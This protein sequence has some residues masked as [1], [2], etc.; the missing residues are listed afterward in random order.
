[1]HTFNASVSLCNYP[2]KPTS[3]E[4][5]EMIFIQ[6]ELN[7]LQLSELI[8]QGHSTCHLFNKK[9]FMCLNKTLKNFKEAYFIVLDFDHSNIPMEEIL[10]TIIIKPTIAFETFSNKEND[11]RFKMIYLLNKVVTD[12]NEYKRMTEM[13]FNIVFN[14]SDRI[15]LKNVL[16]PSSYTA[17]QMFHGTG[18][19]KRVEVFDTLISIDLI[20]QIFELEEKVFE[21]Y[22]EVYQF[23]GIEDS[24]KPTKKSKGK[25]KSKSLKKCPKNGNKRIKPYNIIDFSCFPENGTVKNDLF[26]MGINNEVYFIPSPYNNYQSIQISDQEYD[27]VYYWVGTQKIYAVNT[28]F[29]GGK[30]KV[31]HRK[32]TLQYAA[33]VFCNLYPLISENELFNKLKNYV[34]KYFELPGDIDNNYIRRLAKSVCA[35]D[36]HNDMGRRYFVLNP[37][38][39]QLSKSDKMK[40]LHKRKNEFMRYYILSNHDSSLSLKELADKLKLHPKTVKKYLDTE[41]V[42]YLV[43]SKRDTN[44]QKFIEVYSLAENQKLSGRKLAALCGISNSQVNRYLKVK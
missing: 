25:T 14:E 33:H 13:V 21:N 29:V 9:N 41:G 4:I 35:M 34:I 3:Q 24:F 28:Y 31:G 17:N 15:E 39:N 36:N 42:C 30:Q 10:N 2:S 5:E 20:N 22:E 38:Y 7:T 32:K 19:D 16:D 26:D 23:L 40:E 12:T 43:G 37:A 6:Q 18:K 11:Y 27:K 1:M 8:K 44:Y